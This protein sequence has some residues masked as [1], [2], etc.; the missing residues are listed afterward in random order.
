V[1]IGDFITT[2][3]AMDQSDFK[4]VVFDD[5]EYGRFESIFGGTIRY[6]GDSLDEAGEVSAKI[7]ADGGMALSVEGWH[8]YQLHVGGVVF[9]DED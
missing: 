8:G 7:H 4:W 6:L 1:K 9:Y 3:E 2:K 5:F